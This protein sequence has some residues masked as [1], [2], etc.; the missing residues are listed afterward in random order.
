MNKIAFQSQP[1]LN[2]HDVI[3]I[4]MACWYLGDGDTAYIDMRGGNDIFGRMVAEVEHMLPP[5]TWKFLFVVN[6][7]GCKI[8]VDVDN[9]VHT[10][11]RDGILE[12]DGS[13]F[14]RGKVVL[15][16]DMAKSIVV[17]KGISVQRANEIGTKMRNI[18]NDLIRK[19]LS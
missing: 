3:E 16:E 2:I 12:F 1:N 10:A 11:C 17:S 18:M 4:V 9:F 8:L 19:Y 6:R 13:T 5:W 14:T 15:N 7:Y